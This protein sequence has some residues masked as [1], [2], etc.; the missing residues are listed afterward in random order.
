VVS[1]SADIEH[2]HTF[3]GADDAGDLVVDFRISAVAKIGNTFNDLLHK[4]CSWI[5]DQ[6]LRSMGKAYE[7]NSDT[8]VKG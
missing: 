8:K 5:R 2:G 3:H 6:W 7:G 1:V 4:A